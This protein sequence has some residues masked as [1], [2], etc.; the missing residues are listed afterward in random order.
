MSTHVISVP[1]MRFIAYSDH[2]LLHIVT[3][4]LKYCS[5]KVPT[6]IANMVSY[7]SSC[8]AHCPVNCVAHCVIF[9]YSNMLA[10]NLSSYI[11]LSKLAPGVTVNF[12]VYYKL[13]AFLDSGVGKTF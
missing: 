8:N 3:S 12:K 5:L 10:V 9:G 11:L 13:S 6:T 2:D 4:C 7:F 1:K